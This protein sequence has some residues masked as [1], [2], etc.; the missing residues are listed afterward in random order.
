MDRAIIH[1]NI[2]DF[3]VAVETN[4]QPS[5]RGY[6]VVVA[7]LDAPRA[8]VYD[9]SD[10][11]FRQ[12]IR[13]G[14]PL[15]RAQR[16]NRKLHV[17]P[18]CFNRY[19]RVMRDLLKE[20][21]T[22]TPKIES[23]RLD[24]HIFMDV[25]GSSR[26]FGPPADMAFKLKKSFKRTFNLDPI[27]SV[28]T[29]KLVAKVATRIVKPIGEYIVRPGDE[30]SFLAPLP[31]ELIPGID[32]R[33]LTRLYEFNL[34]SVRQARQLT[35]E[36]LAIPF[37]TDA[38]HVYNRVRGIDPEPVDPVDDKNTHIR[39]DHEFASDTNHID[40]LKKAVYRLSETI[41]TRLRKKNCHADTTQITLSYTDG[42]QSNAQKRLTAP[43]ACDT[44]LFKHGLATLRKAWTRRVRIRHIRLICHKRP[45]QPVQAPLF[46]TSSQ[47]QRRN[48]LMTA[49]AQVRHKF[50]R[51]AVLP[52]LALP[53][54][55][56]KP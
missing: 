21:F 23:G 16:V 40:P 7:P 56:G 13:K 44:A 27:W 33:D 54:K 24:G 2:A 51:D 22:F 38:R 3:A 18:P 53:T 43:T 47:T 42:L 11:A 46:E 1:L 49:M 5:L 48:R 9:I 6:P 35:L 15:A 17:L 8:V 10:E 50:G 45:A 14:M 36:Q 39:A 26:L 30:Q 55:R 4:R 37:S 12:G 41:C 25:T 20:T 28:A 31:L 34:F 19:E 52:A 32:S 29:N